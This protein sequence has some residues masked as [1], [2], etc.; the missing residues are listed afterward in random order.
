MQSA[1][2]ASTVRRMIGIQPSLREYPR[3]LHFEQQESQTRIRQCAD[4]W[5]SKRCYPKQQRMS[6]SPRQSA[7]MECSSH[8][9]VSSANSMNGGMW[10][11][12]RPPHS[13]HDLPVISP[14]DLPLGCALHTGT[15]RSPRCDVFV[16]LGRNG[17]SSTTARTAE[18]DP[19]SRVPSSSFGS[20]IRVTPGRAAVPVGPGVGCTCAATGQSSGHGGRILAGNIFVRWASGTGGNG[21]AGTANSCSWNR[22]VPLAPWWPTTI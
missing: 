6:C 11:R 12:C 8:S 3:S 17:R 18:P 21:V 2:S 22:R 1:C 4:L 14:G 9:T 7:G 20:A 13:G 16:L 15:C 10:L 19:R 5:N